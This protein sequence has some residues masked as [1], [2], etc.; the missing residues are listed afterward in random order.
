M[1]TKAVYAMCCAFSEELGL[2]ALSLIDKEIKIYRIKQNGAKIS[3][4]EHMSFHAKYIITCICISRCASNSRPI[5]CMGSK[6]G[7]IQINYIDESSLNKN[8]D[9]TSRENQHEC[10][11]FNFFRRVIGQETHIQP[12]VEYLKE[13]GSAHEEMI[14]EEDCSG[15]ESAQGT[16]SANRREANKQRDPTQ[17]SQ[18]KNAMNWPFDNE[19]KKKPTID[20]QAEQK[21]NR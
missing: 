11:P 10:S 3:F 12:N 7:D 4:I 20:G 15:S 19:Y 21:E 5:L 9:G 8:K 13:A 14:I 2:L 16:K 17:K 18:L 6:S 1:Q